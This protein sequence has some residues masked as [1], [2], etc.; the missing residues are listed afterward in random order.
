MQLL[1]IEHEVH[2]LIFS[3]WVL[4]HFLIPVAAGEVQKSICSVHTGFCHSR[5]EWG[6]ECHVTTDPRCRNR[7]VVYIY[8]NLLHFPFLFSGCLYFFIRLCNKYIYYLHFS[9]VLC[10]LM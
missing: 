7:V 2:L 5:G 9:H 1:K 3:P 6:R 4:F 8:S 10:I